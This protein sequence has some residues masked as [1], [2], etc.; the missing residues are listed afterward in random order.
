MS[1][2]AAQGEKYTIRRKVFKLFGAAFHI[3]DAQGRVVAYSKQ[4][5]F[6][7]RED[8]RVY[9]DESMSTELLRITTQQIIDFSPR[10]TISLSDGSV[11]GSLQRKGMRSTFVRDE[12]LAFNASGKQIATVNEAGSTFLT[13]ARR[14]IDF[15]SFMFPQAYEL[16]TEDGKHVGTFRQHFNPFVFKMGVT[17]HADD[18]EID[19]LLVLGMGSLIAAIEGREQH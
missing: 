9:T 12:W 6:K 11:V 2:Q 14:W 17:I 16:K 5:A 19:D 10:F 7:L 8:I 15:I 3:Y 1:I 4:K 13:V 18:D